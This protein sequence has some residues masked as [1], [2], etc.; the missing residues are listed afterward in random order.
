MNAIIHLRLFMLHMLV[1]FEH[2]S[3]FPHSKTTDGRVLAEG[4]FQK[5][6]R[7]PS[8]YKGQKVRNQEG[9]YTDRRATQS[10]T[11]KYNPSLRF[12]WFFLFCLFCFYSF[13]FE[14]GKYI[15]LLRF[16]RID[17]EISRHCQVQWRSQHKTEES[18]IFPA[19]FPCQ[20][21][22]FSSELWP[23]EFLVCRWR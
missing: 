14:G 16:S 21:G 5:K 17:K 9:P 8:K 7:D 11:M 1:T 2:R 20:E 10:D 22:P 6:Q 15:Y 4:R 3:K 23:P 13:S 19:M 12:Q 18:Q